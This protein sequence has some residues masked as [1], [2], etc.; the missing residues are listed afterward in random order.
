MAKYCFLFFILFIGIHSGIAQINGQDHDTAYYHSYRDDL[1][2][3]T[4]FSRK[5]TELILNPA[6]KTPEMFYKP[7]T[8]LNVGLGA[9]FHFLTINL[10]VGLNSFNPAQEKGKT[11]Y[12]D[13]Q[14]H[15]YSRK[16][17][18]D[19]LGEFYR[20]YFLSPKGLGSANPSNYY[21]RPDL[22]VQYGGISAFRALNEKKFSYQAGLL[23][24]EWQQKSAGSVLIG[25]ES[26]YGAIDG[27]SSLVTAKV[28]TSFARKGIDRVHFFEIGPGVGYAYTLVI[29]KHY[30]VLASAGINLDLRYSLEIEASS[31]QNRWDLFPN[32][33]FH[34][35]AGYNSNKWVLSVVWVDD[36]I[37]VQG[38]A[39]DY[40]YRITTGNYRLI[41]AVRFGLSRKT[42]RSI[43]KAAPVLIEN[44]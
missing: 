34:A 40:K 2:G 17:N 43:E 23:Q 32:F 18:I 16:W 22:S 31:H 7:N 37:H 25:M 3:R 21:L 6:G 30:F 10:A 38:N 28:D 20:G 5:Y 4:F 41:Y 9:T 12:L 44:K 33:I 8:T 11:H 27:D 1:T 42:K 26:Y 36:Q 19:L 13:L 29:K 24:N 35:G 15:F 39:S 14:S